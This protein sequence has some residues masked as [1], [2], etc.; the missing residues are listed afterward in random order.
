MNVDMQRLE[1]MI[2]VHVDQIRNS[3]LV[4]L[5]L[6]YGCK[7]SSLEALKKEIQSI[8]QLGLSDEDI[9]ELFYHLN[10]CSGILAAE[11]IKRCIDVMEKE[12]QST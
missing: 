10:Y 12:T 11:D 1:E 8:D 4:V 9:N 5:N 7:M 3:S 6:I 2:F